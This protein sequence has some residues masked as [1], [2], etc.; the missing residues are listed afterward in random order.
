MRPCGWGLIG[1]AA[2]GVWSCSGGTDRGEATLER[3]RRAGVVRV[4]F[5]NEAPYAY[6]DRATGQVTGEAPE[7]ARVVFERMNVGRIEGVLTEFGALIPGLQAGRFDLIAAGM[8]ITQPRCAQIAFSNPT[9]SIGEA[10]IVEAG[11][12]L[13]LHSYED[14]RARS[15]ATLGVVSGAIERNYARAVGISDDRIMTFPDPPSAMAAVRAS[16]V[17]AFG[18]TELTVESLL[19]KDRDGL[20]KADPF[21]DPLIERERVRGYGAFGF[22]EG[23]TMLL[24]E[25]NRQLGTFIGTPEHLKLVEPFGFGKPQL[26]GRMTAKELCGES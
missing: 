15:G 21:E 14:V 6:Q 5:A 18:A 3:I 26:P 4:G 20:E 12:P 7:I 23:D 11:N 9:Y 13:G 17:S 10:F 1:I 25:F 19:N 16:R 2:L 24:A 22:R 8:Y